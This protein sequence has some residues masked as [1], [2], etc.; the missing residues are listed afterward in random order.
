MLIQEP[1]ESRP[2]EDDWMTDLDVCWGEKDGT[3]AGY[4]PAGQ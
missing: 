4:L 3:P 2:E 1:V